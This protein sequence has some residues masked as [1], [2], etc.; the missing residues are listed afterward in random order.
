MEP[1]EG[2]GAADELEQPDTTTRPPSSRTEM[3]NIRTTE[4]NADGTPSCSGCST[5]RTRWWPGPWPR[6]CHAAEVVDL[7]LIRVRGGG[8][9]HYFG[10]GCSGRIGVL[11]AAEV[12]PTFRVDASLFVAHHAA[13]RARGTRGRGGRGPESWAERRPPRS[14]PTTGGGPVGQRAH[15]VRGRGARAGRA[16]GALAVLVSS[17]LSAPLAGLPDRSL[18]L[19]PGPRRS[20]VDR[21]RR[22]R[23][24]NDP[25]LAVDAVMIR[26]GRTYSNL[27]VSLSGTNAKLRQ[28]K[29]LILMKTSGATEAGGRAELAAVAVTSG[30]PCCACCPG[31]SRRRP[32]SA[33]AGGS[34]APR[35]PRAGT[36][37]YGGVGWGACGV[38][39]GCHPGSVR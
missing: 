15:S 22:P 29:I 9:V 10:A 18:L 2:G 7:T 13:A 11:D 25:E 33:A 6:S 3:R 32:P 26:L 36:P 17:N 14:P 12:V 34:A 1:K 16:A 31:W 37:G 21:L 28:R 23:P 30:W 24:R 4:I 39:G 35:W 8:H 20:G 27:M 5:L 19:T 38:A